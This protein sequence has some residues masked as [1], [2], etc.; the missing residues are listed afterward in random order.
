MGW[1]KSMKSQTKIVWA[2]LALL[3]LVSYS[4]ACEKRG[5]E[6]KASED[7]NDDRNDNPPNRKTEVLPMIQ[8]STDL[9]HEVSSVPFSKNFKSPVVILGPS[10]SEKDMGV[11]RLHLVNGQK[12]DISFQE[13]PYFD[14]T[15]N[16][17][18]FSFMVL[19]KGSYLL[20]NGAIW[21]VGTFS[22][23]SPPE[24]E[25]P[26]FKEVPLI[27]SFPNAPQV[28]LTIQTLN[29]VDPVTVR[30]AQVTTKSFQASFFEQR[31]WQYDLSHPSHG[32]YF[33]ETVGY[34]AIHSPMVDSSLQTLEGRLDYE[35]RMAQVSHVEVEVLPTYFLRVVE[36][37]SLEN[38][39]THA[40]EDL[41]I[42]QIGSEFYA[43]DNS[44][45]GW[46]PMTLRLRRSP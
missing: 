27:S 30:A 15:H 37:L 36:E 44:T 25:T 5:L 38:D 43:Q 22:L 41:A 3:A 42:L 4:Q 9:T 2:T 10:T 31:A 35:L 23:N 17:E 7:S 28:F 24:S 14:G 21:E 12:M 34:L 18:N 20:P 16:P 39:L 32:H 1:G 11:T 19:E 8:G 26:F 13:W 6:S 40:F 33:E 29:G 46:D 45:Y